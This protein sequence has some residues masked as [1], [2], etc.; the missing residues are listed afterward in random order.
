VNRI[1]AGLDEEVNA[2]TAG[3]LETASKLSGVP[4]PPRP[5][6]RRLRAARA[7]PVIS[8]AV[9][10]PNGVT[11]TVD[12]PPVTGMKSAAPT[13]NWRPHV[14][15]RRTMAFERLTAYLHRSDERRVVLSFA[16]IADI[17]C[18]P[19]PASAYRYPT[20]W[21]N[22]STYARCWREAGYTAT[23]RGLPA[24]HIAFE[25]QGGYAPPAEPAP[26]VA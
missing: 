14:A 13:K 3:P 24:V 11:P 26:L 1:Y 20:F 10:N 25:R 22:A 18:R 2:F 21:W 23:R 19:L 5:P 15:D 8:D 17:E 12:Q 16:D 9:A 7:A 4:R 6:R